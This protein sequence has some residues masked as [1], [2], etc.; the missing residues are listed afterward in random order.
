MNEPLVKI[1]RAA[2]VYGVLVSD[3]DFE[4]YKK[5]DETS[6]YYTYY[7]SSYG[8]NSVRH[9]YQFDQLLNYWLEYDADENEKAPADE[10]GY[11]MQTV[12]YKGIAS[13]E[14]GTP[15]SEAKEES[16]E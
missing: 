14:F 13:Y 2:A 4:E 7:E 9:A 8:E 5:N 15:A 10:N 3:K 12:K 16:A 6:Y 1:Y 11:V